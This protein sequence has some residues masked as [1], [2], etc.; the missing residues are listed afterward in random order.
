MDEASLRTLVER[1][2]DPVMVVDAT[3]VVRFANPAAEEV[4]GRG[5]GAVGHD[6]GIPLV[7]AD[8]TDIDV[9][10]AG[11]IRTFE[12]R[13]VE[14]TWA[15][16]TAQLLTLRDVTERVRHE[17][18][19]VELNR[20]LQVRAEA[21]AV[22]AHVGDGVVLVDGEG[23]VRL[24]N[25][26]AERLLGVSRDMALG[27]RVK[28]CLPAWQQVEDGVVVGDDAEGRL[29]RGQSI[30][31]EDGGQERWLSVTGVRFSA[32]TVFAFHD[33]T[34]EVRA[35]AVRKD[36]IDTA[37]HE[38]RTPLT[39]ISGAAHTLQRPDLDLPDAVRSELLQVICTQSERL[40]KITDDIL[41]TRRLEDEG[42][43]LTVRRFDAGELAEDV[44]RTVVDQAPEHVTLHLEDALGDRREIETDEDKLRQVVANLVQNAV[45]YSPDGGPVTLR[46]LQVEG[47]VQFEVRDQGL[48]I[49]A[50]DLETVFD[51][52]YRAPTSPEAGAIA[53]T[54]LGLYIAREL[55]RR[56][57]GTT[58]VESEEGV[59]ST[60]FVRLP[61]GDAPAEG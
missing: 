47:D 27:S 59:G 29:P 50:A 56:L 7:A 8:K 43:R 15:D 19:I 16:G 51:K 39:S 18:H 21:A 17:E 57:D 6:F 34:E 35:D 38:L 45:K 22:L 2:P 40:Q 11:V 48:G 5:S 32:G 61:M 52:F 23:V 30:V 25:P 10:V 26:A 55:V 42:T 13:V 28:D 3:G 53:G 46:V 36:F 44:L 1:S 41:V 33:L 20:Q 37:S 12:L 31:L 60:F 58:W 24:W 4:F 14:T 49:A 9:P 54:G